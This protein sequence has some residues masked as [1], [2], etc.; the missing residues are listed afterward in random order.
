MWSSWSEFSEG[1]LKWL[2]DVRDGGI[3]YGERLRELAW[4]REGSRGLLSVY[5]NGGCQGDG[6]RLFPVRISYRT[7]LEWLVLA[8]MGSHLLQ[9]GSAQL[10]SY[11]G[12]WAAKMWQ[13]VT[14][15][16]SSTVSQCRDKI[17]VLKTEPQGKVT[18]YLSL[19]G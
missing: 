5:L 7:D 4:R 2:R 14:W 16:P 6:A 8:L 17:M 10:G 13:F 1:L 15:I 9:A 12:W 19:E 3:P 11:G 18:S